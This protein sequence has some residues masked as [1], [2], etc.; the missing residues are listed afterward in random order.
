LPKDPEHGI[1]IRYRYV[2]NEV[3]GFDIRVHASFTKSRGVDMNTYVYY[4]EAKE[5]EELQSCVTTYTMQ[6]IGGT[7]QYQVIAYFMRT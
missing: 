2:G 7:T 6:D 3:R 4:V 5:E 1:W